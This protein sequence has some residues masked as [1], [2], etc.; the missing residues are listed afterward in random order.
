VAFVGVTLFRMIL[1]LFAG[2]SSSIAKDRA[3]A[4]RANVI[5]P[6]T[7]RIHGAAVFVLPN[8]SGRNANFTYAEMLDGFVRL[9]RYIEKS[10]K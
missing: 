7:V 8:P 9:R 6:Q 5:G 1:P 3:A 2:P 4:K 10:V